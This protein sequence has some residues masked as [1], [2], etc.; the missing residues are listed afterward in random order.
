VIFIALSKL[1]V[2]AFV[3]EHRSPSQASRVV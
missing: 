1:I 3:H 2:A